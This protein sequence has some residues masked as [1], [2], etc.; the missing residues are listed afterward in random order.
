MK[1]ITRTQWVLGWIFGLVLG[2]T[3]ILWMI[4][5][6][7]ALEL[8]LF[9]HIS[10]PQ[11]HNTAPT[12]TGRR[13]FFLLFFAIFSPSEERCP[14]CCNRSPALQASGHPGQRGCS[15]MAATSP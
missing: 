4:I 2:T 1:K 15:Q 7:P 14:Q 5:L 10:T 11:Q 12:H 6:N 13:G 9:E 3:I 8:K